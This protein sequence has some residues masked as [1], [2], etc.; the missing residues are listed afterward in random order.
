[1]L[2]RYSAVPASWRGT[3]CG[4]GATGTFGNADRAW[5]TTGPQYGSSDIDTGETGP[6]F[7]ELDGVDVRDPCNV[8]GMS[9]KGTG[10]LRVIP[11]GVVSPAGDPGVSLGSL[12]KLAQKAALSAAVL[13]T[14]VVSASAGTCLGSEKGGEVT[15]VAFSDV[16]ILLRRLRRRM[17]HQ[18]ATA[19]A[20]RT[21]KAP[22]PPPIAAFVL[23]GKLLC[24]IR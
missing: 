14:L 11:R 3:T 5:L 19:P 16:T 20:R 17:T 21:K 18:A 10:F 22:S 4:D 1:M 24:D 9:K 23:F 8:D 15:G 6:L 12:S 7:E 13:G 2:G